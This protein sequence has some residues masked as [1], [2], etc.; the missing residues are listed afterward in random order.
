M[1]LPTL[2]TEISD[3]PGMHTQQDEIEFD[4]IIW[5]A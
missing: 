1:K 3:A 2:Y 4:E 5:L